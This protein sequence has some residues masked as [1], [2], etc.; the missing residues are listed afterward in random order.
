MEKLVLEIPYA[1]NIIEIKGIGIKTVAGFLPK[2]VISLS[3]AI[4]S[5]LIN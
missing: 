3:L 5:R 1:M 4:R 2:L